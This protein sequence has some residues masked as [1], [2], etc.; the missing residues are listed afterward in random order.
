MLPEE[1]PKLLLANRTLVDL[2][3]RLPRRRHVACSTLCHDILSLRRQCPEGDTS[4]GMTP[5]V[6]LLPNRR[7]RGQVDCRSSGS[8][9]R[10]IWIIAPFFCSCEATLAVGGLVSRDR[11]SR[12]ACRAG[13]GAGVRS[14]CGRR[15]HCASSRAEEIKPCLVVV[16]NTVVGGGCLAGVGHDKKGERGSQDSS[17]PYKSDGVA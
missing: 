8:A 5:L 2:C 11:R 6:A 12:Q 13:R 17:E 1:K 7:R 4:C 16:G 3:V 15:S 14:R 9:W 10:D